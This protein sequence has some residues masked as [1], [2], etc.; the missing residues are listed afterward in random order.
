MKI[1]LVVITVCTFFCSTGARAMEGSWFGVGS[2]YENLA[3]GF[4]ENGMSLAMEGGYWYLGNVAYGGFFK[5]N[6][7]GEANSTPNTNLKIYDLGV[8]W[9]A[10]T[11]EGLYGKILTGVAFINADGPI[12]NFKV[13][14]GH[15][16]FFGLGGG[17]S[18]PV[19]ETLKI[20][21]EVIYRHLT[22]GNGGD[23]IS[24]GALVT[25]GF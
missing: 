1:L 4:T 19:T 23:Q 5:A 17:F 7:F 10:A 15:S 22:A 11:D 6:F 18:F 14:D 8:F 25:H 24:I 16:W 9:K 2:S 20:G 13:G 12:T 21:P 3:S